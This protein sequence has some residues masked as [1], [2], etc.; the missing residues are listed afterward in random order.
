MSILRWRNSIRLN[1][2]DAETYLKDSGKEN[3]PK[4]VQE[5]N[6]TMQEIKAYWLLEDSPESRLLVAVCFEELVY[7]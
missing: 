1:G 5:Y 6:K 2:I 3:L 4:T 7:E